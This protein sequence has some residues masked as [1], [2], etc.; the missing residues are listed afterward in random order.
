MVIREMKSLLIRELVIRKREKMKNK[1]T[2]S[3]LLEHQVDLFIGG[4]DWEG[5]RWC[6]Q[7][8][9]GK[10]KFGMNIRSV[11]KRLTLQYA[12]GK[13]ENNST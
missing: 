3:V 12:G 13:L 6:A 11:H 8:G 1:Y 9:M 7:N 2:L 5:R 10:I 4:K